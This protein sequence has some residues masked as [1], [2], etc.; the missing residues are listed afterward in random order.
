M[1]HGVETMGPHGVRFRSRL[2]ARWAAF[3]DLCKISWEYEPEVGVEGW[4]PDFGLMRVGQPAML[5]E[6][7]P[8]LGLVDLIPHFDR[9]EKAANVKWPVLLVGGAFALP[10]E[11]GGHALGWMVKPYR[12]EISWHDV[13]DELQ[14]P[15]L[16][17]LAQQL[18]TKA[19]NA[20]QWRP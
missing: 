14:V 9:I 4:I 15:I 2:E 7:K 11:A 1:P 6:V 3:F 5:V 13:A 12:R 17:T 10:M 8:E 18:W 16:F 19:G 20:L